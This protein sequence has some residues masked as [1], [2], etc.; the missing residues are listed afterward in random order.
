MTRK[1]FELV[2]QAFATTKPPYQEP[3][4][5]TQWLLDI[6]LVADVLQASNPLFNRSKFLKAC[7]CSF[8][9]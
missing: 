6:R 9:I 7:S 2:A 4:R 1:H 5:E 8:A 3:E